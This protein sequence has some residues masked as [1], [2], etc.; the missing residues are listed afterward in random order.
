[1][2]WLVNESDWMSYEIERGWG[3]GYVIM[4]K[5]HPWFLIPYSDICYN[6]YFNVHGGLTYGEVIDEKV[7]KY[8]SG[9]TKEDIGCYMIGFDTA[10]YG[11][12]IHKWPKE[13]VIKET[14][15][16]FRQVQTLG[17][18]YTLL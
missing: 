10:H 12:T 9:L 15:E 11:D 16:L 18:K 6:M 1:M 3:N 4:Q 2:R 8:W 5:S 17:G 14:K 13:A 7:L